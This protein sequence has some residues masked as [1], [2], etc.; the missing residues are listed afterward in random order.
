MF[1]VLVSIFTLVYFTDCQ[2]GLS[3]CGGDLQ[4]GI[5]HQRFQQ[6]WGTWWIHIFEFHK[7]GTLVMKTWN[8]S[9]FSMQ[10]VFMKI[11]QEI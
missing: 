3:N 2:I 11:E 4:L 9:L 1:P 8:T 10:G 5:L 7:W 6:I